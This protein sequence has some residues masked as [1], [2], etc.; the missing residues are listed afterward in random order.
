MAHGARVPAPIKLE[1]LGM[2]GLGLPLHHRFSGTF[3]HG[4]GTYQLTQV[5]AVLRG[6]VSHTLLV[7]ALQDARERTRT[8]SAQD[9]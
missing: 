9:L 3:A 6:H 5:L 1:G 8:T 4:H 2:E 7:A